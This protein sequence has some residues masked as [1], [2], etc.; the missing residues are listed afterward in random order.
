MPNVTIAPLPDLATV[1][2]R[3]PEVHSGELVFAGTRVPV[4]ALLD[5]MRHGHTVDNF[6]EGFPTVERWQA[7]GFLELA[8]EGKLGQYGAADGGRAPAH[9]GRDRRGP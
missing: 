2:S 4:R 5:H 9:F 7:E 6:L 3:D 1:V 8:A